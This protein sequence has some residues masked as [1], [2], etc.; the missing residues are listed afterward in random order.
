M[1]KELE[2]I[3]LPTSDKEFA[4]LVMGPIIFFFI[5][6][7]NLRSTWTSELSQKVSS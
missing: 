3:T 5:H 6:H 1:V 4:G 2:N 7:K